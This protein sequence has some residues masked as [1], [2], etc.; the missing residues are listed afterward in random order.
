M[1]ILFEAD[2]PSSIF[3]RIIGL[4]NLLLLRGPVF[5]YQ[6][7]VTQFVSQMTKMWQHGELSNFEYLMHLN[8]AA[9]RSYNDLTQYPV[10]PWVLCDY[11]SKTL[12]LNNPKVYRDLSKPM[13]ALGARRA[14][15]YRERYKSMEELKRT[16]MAD[17][18]PPPF[19]YGTHYSCAGLVTE[20]FILFHIFLY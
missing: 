19:H 17:G 12:D 20:F 2:L 3:S 7:Y 6:R 4:K 1:Q 8:A 15:H 11:S 14:R 9:G 16:G 13:G 10:F 18:T 5:I